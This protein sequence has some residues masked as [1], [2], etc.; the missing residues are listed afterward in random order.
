MRPRSPR[1]RDGSFAGPSLADALNEQTR[2]YVKARKADAAHIVGDIA[3]ILRTGGSG[4]APRSPIKAV[5][6]D[7]ANGVD[8]FSGKLAE[9]SL[10]EIYAEMNAVVRKR[11]LVMAAT[12]SLAGLAVYRFVTAAR[13]APAR[14]GPRSFAVTQSHPEP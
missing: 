11:P 4:F 8:A 10:R 2:T 14:P 13:A 9:G 3:G 12:A 5:L 1:P 6:D 7:A